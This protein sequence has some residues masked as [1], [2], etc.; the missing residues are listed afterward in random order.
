MYTGLLRG[1]AGEGWH[2]YTPQEGPQHAAQI[3]AKGIYEGCTIDDPGFSGHPENSWVMPNGLTEYDFWVQAAQEIHRLGMYVHLQPTVWL[4][5]GGSEACSVRQKAYLVALMTNGTYTDPNTGTV[6]TK[7]QDLYIRWLKG[8]VQALQPEVVA[9]FNEPCGPNSDG[10]YNNMS[11]YEAFLN[12]AMAEVNA[13]KSG[14]I[15]TVAGLPFWYVKTAANLNLIVPAGCRLILAQHY[16]YL[17][18]GVDPPTYPPDWDKCLQEYWDGDFT[19]AKIDMYDKFLY[20][21]GMQE[22]FDR[23]YTVHFEELGTDPRAPNFDRF[24]RDAYQFCIDHDM[25][26]NAFNSQ[27]DW[28]MRSG[29]WAP[30]GF[31]NNPGWTLNPIGQIWVEF[32]KPLLS[33]IDF[34]FLRAFQ[35]GNV[36]LTLVR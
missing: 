17:Y 29:V 2:Y 11:Q 4:A 3:G 16:Y 27:A 7:V 22:A 36:N 31:W 32:Q 20:E 8:A 14:V 10:T 28:S 15:I 30:G 21:F 25:G 9:I 35:G 23:G 19:Q 34:R 26:W 5:G 1:L 13:T 33:T 12:R 18:S 24:L 6:L